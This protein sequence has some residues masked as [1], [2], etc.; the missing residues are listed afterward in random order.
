M[1]ADCQLYTLLSSC[2]SFSYSISYHPPVWLT[3]TWVFHF[4]HS[5]TAPIFLLLWF[6]STY[7]TITKLYCFSYYV[8]CI[9]ASYNQHHTKSFLDLLKLKLLASLD[10]YMCVLFG[11]N[12]ICVN[13]TMPLT[14]QSIHITLN[15]TSLP[16]ELTGHDNKP[17]YH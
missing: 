2:G 4:D 7:M 6:K 8:I 1:I 13:Q 17:L 3:D 10:H 11:I 14:S 16:A 9:G 12:K 15:F 5:F